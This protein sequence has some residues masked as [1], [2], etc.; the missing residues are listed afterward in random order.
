MYSVY[1]RFWKPRVTAYTF[2]C[3][4]SCHVSHTLTVHVST[5]LF[6]L[7]SHCGTVFGQLSCAECR[8]WAKLE[9][10][11]IKLPI[12]SPWRLVVGLVVYHHSFL[13]STLDAGKWSVSFWPLI[14]TKEPQYHNIGGWMGPI[15]GLAI[16]GDEKNLLEDIT[17]P[18]CMC[19][20]KKMLFCLQCCRVF[21]FFQYKW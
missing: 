15:C 19:L 16:F 1:W 4:P 7:P 5:R 10:R 14:A 2:H 18:K 9:D 3:E 13:T 21:K 6:W 17:V 20:F 11:E 12:S 8:Y